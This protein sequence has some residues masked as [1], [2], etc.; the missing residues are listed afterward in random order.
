MTKKEKKYYRLAF[1]GIII[2]IVVWGIEE[3]LEL[4]LN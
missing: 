2:G 3:A 4:G 1:Y